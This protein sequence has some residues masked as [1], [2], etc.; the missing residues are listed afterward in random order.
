[1][2]HKNSP[3]RGGEQLSV[4]ADSLPGHKRHTGLLASR[5]AGF[6]LGLSAHQKSG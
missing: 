2:G 3:E 1:M 6:L 5:T 4:P